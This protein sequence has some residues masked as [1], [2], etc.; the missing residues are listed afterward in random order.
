MA[1]KN[2]KPTS[3]ARRGLVLVQSLHPELESG[4][5]SFARVERTLKSFGKVS[6]N[7]QW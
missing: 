4:D 3:P 2:Y 1:L 5:Q 7:V 6:R